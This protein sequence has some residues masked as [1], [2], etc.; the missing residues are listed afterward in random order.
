MSHV[1]RK[2]LCARLLQSVCACCRRPGSH[3]RC[4]LLHPGEGRAAA[5]VRHAR[6][7]LP[8]RRLGHEHRQRAQRRRQWCATPAGSCQ[9]ASLQIM[10]WDADKRRAPTFAA[11]MTPPAGCMVTSADRTKVSST[12]AI[13]PDHMT[14]NAFMLDREEV[15]TTDT[16][17]GWT[18]LPPIST[19]VGQQH[20]TRFVMIASC[21]HARRYADAYPMRCASVG[22]GCGRAMG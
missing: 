4:F 19:Q 11:F 20:L 13:S 5:R 7:W 3:W 16:Q 1:L 17:Q 6:R 21:E 15:H 8:K 2:T 12:I 14:E 18:M 10:K 9:Q 22:S